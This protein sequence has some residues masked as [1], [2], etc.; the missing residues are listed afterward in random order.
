MKDVKFIVKELDHGV[1]SFLDLIYTEDGKSIYQFMAEQEEELKQE[2]E[3]KARLQR[4][5]EEEK[6]KLKREL[7]EKERIAKAQVIALYKRNTPFMDIVAI[8]GYTG[9]HVWEIIEEYRKSLT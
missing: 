8:L 6:A 7:E 3:E 9:S 5:A 2:K 1:T 4:E